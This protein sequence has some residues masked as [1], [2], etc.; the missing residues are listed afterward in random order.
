M[1]T[2]LVLCEILFKYIVQVVNH[3][4]YGIW[5]NF[6][7]TIMLYCT[8]EGPV[9]VKVHVFLHSVHLWLYK[10]IIAMVCMLLKKIP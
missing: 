9:W 7:L 2:I 6:Y 4:L 10:Y 3:N 5:Q 1:W 8:L